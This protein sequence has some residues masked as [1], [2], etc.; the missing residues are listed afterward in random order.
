MTIDHLS[1]MRQAIALSLRSVREGT[2]GP[3]G[4]VIVKDGEIVGR[5]QNQVAAHHD[6]T[7][8]AEVEALR[9]AG[10]RLGTENLSGC[11]V[12]ASCEPCPMCHAALLW[13]KV[14]AVYYATTHEE[15]ARYGFSIHFIQ[16]DLQRP[17]AER[18]IIAGQ[19][20]H[21]EAGEAFAEWRRLNPASS[22]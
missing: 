15:A 2:G 8:H 3:F 11:T 19:V 20:G 10:Q 5:G 12:Y 18:T 14:S 21:A 9:D 22:G 7:A 17:L 16:E 1:F 4:C 6:P 13:A